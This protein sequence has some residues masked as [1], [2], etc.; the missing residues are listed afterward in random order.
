MD[1]PVVVEVVDALDGLPHEVPGL[2]LRHRLPAL[3][4][5]QQRLEV[6]SQRY[7]KHQ[8]T[9]LKHSPENILFLTKLL[10]SRDSETAP[11]RNVPG[12][13]FFYSIQKL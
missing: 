11:S 2:G 9:A 5:L 1:D 10:E 4:Q 12:F 3:V 7:V 13:F 8:I 6:T